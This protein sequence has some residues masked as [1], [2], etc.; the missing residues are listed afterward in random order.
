MGFITNYIDKQILNEKSLSRIW[1]YINSG[2]AFGIISAYRDSLYSEQVNLQRHRELQHDVRSLGY[3]YVD[4]DGGYT[5]QD[6][7]YGTEELSIERSLF[8]PDISLKNLLVLGKKYNQESVIYKDTNR[9]DLISPENGM[10]IMSF[11][12]ENKARSMTMDPQTLKYAFTQ[13]HNR[14]N[15]KSL[16]KKAFA[17]SAA[18]NESFEVRELIIPSQ[19]DSYKAMKE[20]KKLTA[21]WVKII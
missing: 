5:Y 6:P 17:F 10:S 18:A 12:K 19:L 21:R 15:K 16:N 14:N 11:D 20:Q 13:F 4:M 3:G 7:K 8:I 9:F 2:R 1:M